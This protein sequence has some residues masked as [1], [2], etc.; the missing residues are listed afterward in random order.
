[1]SMVLVYWVVLG[2]RRRAR[3]SERK[4]DEWNWEEGKERGKGRER[5]RG[6]GVIYIVFYNYIL[7]DGIFRF[8]DRHIDMNRMK[9]IDLNSLL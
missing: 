7:K 3:E 6:G 9:S 1:M 4:R 8:N 5:E 2:K